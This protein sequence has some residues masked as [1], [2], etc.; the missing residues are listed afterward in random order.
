MTP[1]EPGIA[2]NAKAMS[3]VEDERMDKTQV[4]KRKLKAQGNDF[5]FWQT[6]PYEKRMATIEQLRK[7]YHHDD[8]QSRL[9]RVYRIV[10]RP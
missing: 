2:H 10:K 8:A 3:S 7:E 9:Q 5:L 4:K 1:V 6:Q